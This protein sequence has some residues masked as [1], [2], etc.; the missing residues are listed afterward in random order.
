MHVDVHAFRHDVVVRRL[1]ED[2]AQNGRFTGERDLGL[3]PIAASSDGDPPIARG[4]P[5]QKAVVGDFG[6]DACSGR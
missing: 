5:H 2:R 4:K 1:H 3:I 6:L